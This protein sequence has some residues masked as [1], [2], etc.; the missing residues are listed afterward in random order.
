MRCR[1]IAAALKRAAEGCQTW[2]KVANV[3]DAFA[4]YS[5]SSTPPGAVHLRTQHC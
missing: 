1:E 5:L 3:Q 2:G 4:H